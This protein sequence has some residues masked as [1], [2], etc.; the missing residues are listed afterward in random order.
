[1]VPHLGAA[2][3]A[4]GKKWSL[5]VEDTDFDWWHGEAAVPI[6]HPYQRW[7]FPDQREKS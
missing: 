4:A 7:D 6:S 3:P 1:M 2:I 5:L